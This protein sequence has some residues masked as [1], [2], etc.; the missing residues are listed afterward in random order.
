MLNQVKR[1]ELVLM[2]IRENQGDLVRRELLVS[3]GLMDQM[4]YQDDPVV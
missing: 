3:M 1:E 4:E 2:D